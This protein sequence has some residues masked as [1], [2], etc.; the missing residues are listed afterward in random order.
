MIDETNVEYAIDQLG[1]A[2]NAI[3]ITVPTNQALVTIQNQSVGALFQWWENTSGDKNKS[4]TLILK[5]NK[6]I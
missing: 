3:T 4:I 2:D 6:F 5:K 1:I